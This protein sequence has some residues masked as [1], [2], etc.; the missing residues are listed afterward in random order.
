MGPPGYAGSLPSSNLH[1]LDFRRV[2]IFS[3]MKIG[4]AIALSAI[5]VTKLAAVDSKQESAQELFRRASDVGPAAMKSP[6]RIQYKLTFHEGGTGPVEGT[7]SRVWISRHQWRV[8]MSMPSFSDV[9]VSDGSS[10][11]VLRKP[12]FF[13]PQMVSQLESELLL[14]GEVTLLPNEKVSKISEASDG[15]TRLKCVEIRRPNGMPTKSLCF[16]QSS[17]ALVR[18]KDGKQRTEFSNFQNFSGALTARKVRH[19]RG[20][21]LDSEAELTS[22]DAQSATA[23]GVLDHAADSRQFNICEGPVRAGRLVQR[24]SPIYPAAARLSH[25]TGTVEMYAV[26]DT[27]GTLKDLEIVHGA[28][29]LLD[30]AAM[31]ALRKW[32]YEPYKC[33]GMPVQVESMVSVTFRL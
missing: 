25:Q 29:T 10:R 8:E 31:E 20:S 2:S 15:A 7:Y 19:F 24:E 18:A 12:H 3:P 28:S 4:F 21:T 5:L 9:E 33:D 17:G 14:T 23:S 11:W 6:Y 30:A 22:L 1:C 32:R 26:I 27:D 16:D 13:E